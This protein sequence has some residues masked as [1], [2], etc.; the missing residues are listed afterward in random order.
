MRKMSLFWVVAC[1]MLFN[2]ITVLATAPDVLVSHKD[3]VGD[4]LVDA[5]GMTLYWSKL[6]APGGSRCKGQCLIQWPPFYKEAILS[7]SPLIK[8]NDFGTIIR[9]DGKK[10]NTFRGYPLYYYTMDQKP[11]DTKGQN[12]N[13]VWFVMDPGRFKVIDVEHTGWSEPKGTNK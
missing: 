1:L 11:G 12:L 7:S 3:G 6:D 8:S 13:N 2:A 5:N 9:S 10:Q 4:Y